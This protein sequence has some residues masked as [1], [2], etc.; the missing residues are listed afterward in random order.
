M[1]VSGEPGA[2]RGEGS[3]EEE[4]IMR[5]E[6]VRGPH[7]SEPLRAVANPA[8]RARL[9]VP[10][11]LAH[12]AGFAAGGVIGAAAEVAL[13]CAQPP[14][15]ASDTTVP[16]GLAAGGAIGGLLQDR[17]VR[18]R[19]VPPWRW[20]AASL[21]GL[22]VGLALGAAAGGLPEMAG[23]WGGPRGALAALVL[24]VAPTVTVAQWLT[25]RRLA[26]RAG[27]WLAAATLAWAVSVPVSWA[28]GLLVGFPA[29][30]VAGLAAGG[31]AGGLVGAVV[32]VAA[33]GTVAGALT[34]AALT[35][36]LPARD[37][38]G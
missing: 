26:P 13:D 14:A 3:S 5:A 30:M 10:W 36:L 38:A 17:L 9:W 8:D 2:G 27:W 21:A 18:R 4:D 12:A 28:V 15:A 31:F 16:V 6:P 11:T 7:G 37:R 35:C 24:N 20:T 1:C 23:T 29:T 25:L 33:V 19:G 34:G 32:L 22:L